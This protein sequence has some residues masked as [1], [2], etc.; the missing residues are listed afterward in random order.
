[1]T[2]KLE[3]FEKDLKFF[4]KDLK[5]SEK[6]LKFFEKFP[7]IKKFQFFNETVQC[8]RWQK[9]KKHFIE[10]RLLLQQTMHSNSA[11]F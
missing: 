1:M 9:N 4:E 8:A 2:K 6:D 10:I 11:L 7:V 5:F 3:N